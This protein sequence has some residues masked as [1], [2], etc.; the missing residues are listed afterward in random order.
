MLGVDLGGRRIIERWVKPSISGTEKFFIIQGVN[1]TNG[2]LIGLTTSEIRWRSNGTTDISAVISK[3]DWYHF[4]ITRSGSGS[5]NVKVFVDGTQVTQGTYTNTILASA[6]AL[7]IGPGAALSSGFASYGY[8]D[9]FRI[10][11]GFARYTAG[12]TPRGSK[13]PDK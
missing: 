8:I 10:T 6:G 1:Q 7:N 12:F 4:A 2:F 9:D 5:N 3:A 11:R 13:F